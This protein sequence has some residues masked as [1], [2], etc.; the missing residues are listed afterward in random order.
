MNPRRGQPRMKLNEAVRQ[1][2]GSRR[3]HIEQHATEY[4]RAFHRHIYALWPDCLRTYAQA[5][6]LT[7]QI[8]DELPCIF[9]PPFSDPSR[10]SLPPALPTWDTAGPPPRVGMPQSPEDPIGMNTPGGGWLW[11]RTHLERGDVVAVEHDGRTLHFGEYI[12]CM[13]IL[14]YTV[15]ADAWDAHWECSEAGLKPKYA[16]DEGFGDPTTPRRRTC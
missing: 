15:H 5:Y 7:I 4:L 3:H 8:R 12:H 16:I 2:R 1:W 14:A 10:Q 13:M 6:N 11:R 9:L